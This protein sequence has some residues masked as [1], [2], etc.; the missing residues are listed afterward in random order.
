MAILRAG[1][2]L[3]AVVVLATMAAMAAPNAAAPANPN[4]ARAR[5]KLAQAAQAAGQG[6]HHTVVG[7]VVHVHR[8]A[9]DGNKGIITVRMGSTHHHR[10]ATSAVAQQHRTVKVHVNDATQFQR[11][12]AGG[13]NQVVAASFGDVHNGKRVKI[14]RHAADQQ[15]ASL[16]NILEAGNQQHRNT[17]AGRRVFFGSGQGRTVAVGG[18]TTVVRKRPLRHPLVTGQVEKRL[19]RIQTTLEH[20]GHR[21]LA[22]R[23]K[24]V[25]ERIENRAHSSIVAHHHPLIRRVTIAHA[26]TGKT[27]GKVERIV[28]HHK[29]ATSPRIPNK[30]Q[31]TEVVKK[32]TVARAAVGVHQAVKPTTISKAFAPPSGHK[33]PSAQPA[34][35]GSSSHQS[36]S[37]HKK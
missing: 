36:S 11:I 15:A 31:G 23:A 19:E 5:A 3:G 20:T 30:P 28:E 18:T 4:A 2:A 22:H 32:T 10:T 21:R 8:N 26:A 12:V 9:Q 17:T 37:S 25:E 24:R 1:A 13:Q 27:V 29:P 16:V 34:H 14:L 35:R 6:N 33:P 7:T